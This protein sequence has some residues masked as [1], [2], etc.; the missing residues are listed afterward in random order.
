MS[1]E[2]VLDRYNQSEKRQEASRRYRERHR[3]KLR[4]TSQEW[5]WKNPEKRKAYARDYY[6]RNKQRILD[7]SS[8]YYAENK[9][10]RSLTQKAWWDEAKKLGKHVGYRVA[11]RNKMDAAPWGRV[12]KNARVNAKRAGVAFDLTLEW[13]ASFGGICAVSGIPFVPSF[14]HTGPFT[15]SVDRL[16]PAK[17][18]TQA[19][20]R[21]VIWAVNRFRGEHGDDTMW[22]VVDAMVAARERRRKE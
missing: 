22:A 19:N 9:G 7:Q 18:Y 4:Q 20:C 12:L 14:G 3:E 21:L 6:Q 1:R 15:P 5:T 13:A 10:Q 17:G 8:K 2:D 16:D 11:R